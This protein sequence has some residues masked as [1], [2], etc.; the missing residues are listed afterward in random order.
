MEHTADLELEI[1][2]ETVAALFQQA[3]RG[4]KHLLQVR[5]N[6]STRTTRQ[7][8]VKAI[9]YEGLLVDFL[10]E[11]L[12]LLERDGL[13]FQDLELELLNNSQLSVKFHGLPVEAFHRE[14]KA[15]TYHNLEVKQTEQGWTANVVFDI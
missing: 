13:I 5:V 15:V 4:M 6:P 14:I 9:D 3:A 7:F 8:E 2:G 1:W 12:F 10:S 11:L